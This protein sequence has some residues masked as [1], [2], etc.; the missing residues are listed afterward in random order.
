MAVARA[1]ADTRVLAECAC[2][3]AGL[4]GASSHPKGAT[5]EDE[6]AAAAP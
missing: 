5:I 2:R 4:A 6:L 1:V 3:S